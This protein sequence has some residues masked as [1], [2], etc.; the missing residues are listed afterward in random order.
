MSAT[1]GVVWGGRLAVD[2]PVRRAEEAALHR[3]VVA[4]L[5]GWLPDDAWSWHTPNGGLRH[6]K[7]GARMVGLGVRAGIPDLFVLWRGRLIGIELKA[8]RGAVS[9]VQKQAFHK[10]GHCGCE[11]FVCG[12]LA[13]VYA[14]LAEW[15]MPLPVV[16][17][18]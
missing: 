12:A 17:F 10:L 6:D 8:E 7:V 9:A 1:G 15:G 2:K 14:L 13:E 18:Q 3:S 4:Q 5:R 16:R 11:V